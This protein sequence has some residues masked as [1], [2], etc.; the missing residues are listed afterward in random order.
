[1]AIPNIW[2]KT[3]QP[4]KWANSYKLYDDGSI[5]NPLFGASKSTTIYVIGIRLADMFVPAM[6]EV[7]TLAP[8]GYDYRVFGPCR[9]GRVRRQNL[10]KVTI[11]CS[12]KTATDPKQRQIQQLN[13]DTFIGVL[14]EM[15]KKYAAK[16]LQ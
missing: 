4:V 1:M 2:E 15:V 6:I 3:N 8:D 12:P 14:A 10:H 13:Y 5:K 9:D 11:L 16:V 7:K